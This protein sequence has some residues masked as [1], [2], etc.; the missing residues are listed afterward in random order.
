[1]PVLLLAACVHRMP[2][3]EVLAGMVEVPAGPFLM[4]HAPSDGR[5]GVDVGVDSLP[6]HEVKV[7]RFWIDRTEATV[8]DYK[9]YL[10]AAGAATFPKH[11]YGA[12]DP[13]E[14]LPIIGLDHS[15]ASA[16]CRWLGKRLP[17]EAEWEK[18]A[19]GTDGRIFP[20]GNAW[21]PDLVA[22]HD[23]KRSR[24]DPVGSHPENASPYGAVDMAGNVME[25]TDSWYEGYPGSTLQRRAFGHQF[26]VLKGGSWE[27]NPYQLRSANRF[28]V[29]P[30]IGQP[31][32]G[33]RCV[34]SG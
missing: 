27:S 23:H 5:P 14:D 34:A 6:R 26:R 4:G 2:P 7:K 22:Y 20:W 25:W 18:A 24:P 29:L 32:F 3:P 28:A 10:A 1:L 21:A 16:Y 9:R 17:T 11:F 15:E 19:R 33:V 30:E 12:A 13:P 31:S 8:A